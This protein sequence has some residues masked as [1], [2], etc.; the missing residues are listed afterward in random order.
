MFADRDSVA[1][2]E[3]HGGADGPLVSQHGG[4][5][6]RGAQ[7]GAQIP[8]GAQ[9]DRSEGPSLPPA[10]VPEA[11]PPEG[12]AGASPL[13]AVGDGGNR[14]DVLL[15]GEGGRE[16]AVPGADQREPTEAWTQQDRAEKDG[17]G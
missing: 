7:D 16:G 1:Q 9:Q 13:A 6:D 12:A 10:G 4:G 8:V 2:L 3:A 14:G 11:G 5:D 17:Q 15:G